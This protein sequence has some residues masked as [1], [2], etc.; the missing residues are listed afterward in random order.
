MRRCIHNS[1]DNL[2]GYRAALHTILAR[3]DRLQKK[4][5]IYNHSRK[6]ERPPEYQKSYWNMSKKI[7]TYRKA[8]RNII[9]YQELVNKAGDAIEQFLGVNVKGLRDPRK[10]ELKLPRRI[11]VKYLLE[12]RV[13]GPYIE[14]YLGLKSTGK[15]ACAIVRK[16]F[17]K[18]FSE[19]PEHR[20]L[21]HRFVR[22]MAE[23]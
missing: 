16:R 18:S 1:E 3:R 17:N 19:Y 14:K 7:Y 22:Y 11:F 2:K 23:V 4:F 15:G 6:V 8:I 12:A 13:P 5:G 21:Y 10:E 20:E 9:A